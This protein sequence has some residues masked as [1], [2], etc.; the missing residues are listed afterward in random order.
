MGLPQLVP[1]GPQVAV[2][3]TAFT[4]DALGRYVC[5]TWEEATGSGGA[6]FTAVIVGAGAYGAYLA[7][8]LYRTRPAARILVLDAGSFL[9]GEHVQNL[10]PVGFN[11]PAPTGSDPGTARELVWG[12]PWR[13]NVEFPGLAYCLGGK[14]LYWGGWCP[15]LTAGRPGAVAGGRRGRPAT[16]TTT[17]WRATPAWCRTPTSSSGSSTRR[18]FRPSGR[19]WARCPRWR[20]SRSAP[21]AVQGNAPASGLFSFDKYSSLPVLVDAVRRDVAASGGSDAARRLFVVPRAHVVAL[22]TADGAVGT[23]E[24]EVAGQRRFLTVDAGVRSCSRPAPSR[25]R[26]WRC[27]R[28][29]R[30]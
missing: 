28:S 25:A 15:R 4:T 5:S 19:R 24:V 6:P 21:L 9:V 23:V 14:S 20:R 2:Q 22:H 17:P 27:S 18:C 13:G 16:R 12:L 3:E 30:R 10:G 8:A 1:A 29:R 7:G 11:V 26:G